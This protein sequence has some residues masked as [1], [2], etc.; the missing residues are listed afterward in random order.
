LAAGVDF[1]L[2]T[3]KPQNIIVGSGALGMFLGADL[4]LERPVGLVDVV[5][6][7]APVL[8]E[9]AGNVRRF[10]AEEFVAFQRGTSE[11][12]LAFSAAEIFFVCVPPH[13]TSSVVDFLANTVLRLNATVFFCGNGLLPNAHVI[14]KKNPS[15]SLCRALFHA[16]FQRRMSSAGTRIVHAGGTRVEWGVIAGAR[17]SAPQTR[18]LRWEFCENIVQK[19]FEKFFINLVLAAVVGARALPNGVLLERV[20]EAQL[21][22]VANDFCGMFG[23]GRFLA[24]DFVVALVR[25]VNQTSANINSVSLARSSGNNEAWEALLFQLWS[26]VENAVD[27]EAGTRFW[28]F[29]S[30]RESCS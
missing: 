10:G 24:Q 26:V 22:S 6:V 13:I 18:T 4:E 19:E 27:P 17:P 2:N 16:G 11:A 7:C 12:E 30:L 25:T 21:V 3:S 9:S 20:P 5:P 29:V 15:V 14:L 1:A 8:I 23:N 28:N